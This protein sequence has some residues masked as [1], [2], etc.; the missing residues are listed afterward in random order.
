V[1]IFFIVQLLRGCRLR[2]HATHVYR[3]AR[4]MSTAFI[5]AL[6]LENAKWE[7]AYP[8]S[9]AHMQGARKNARNRYRAF[10]EDSGKLK[11]GMI[12]YINR[13][14]GATVFGNPNWQFAIGPCYSSSQER[15]AEE[16]TV[17]HIRRRARPRTQAV[18]E[19]ADKVVKWVRPTPAHSAY[20]MESETAPA[21]TEMWSVLSILTPLAQAFRQVTRSYNGGDGS[22]ASKRDEEQL[23]LIKALLAL[24]STCKTALCA[25]GDGRLVTRPLRRQGIHLHIRRWDRRMLHVEA[26]GVAVMSACTGI[27]Q[28]VDSLCKKFQTEEAGGMQV[29][30]LMSAW[31][32]EVGHIDYSNGNAC[33]CYDKDEL[34]KHHV[35][36][37]M[38]K[39]TNR[40]G[41]SRKTL[42]GKTDEP[43]SFWKWMMTPMARAIRQKIRDMR[44]RLCA[45]IEQNCAL[46]M[47]P[48]NRPSMYLHGNALGRSDINK[49]GQYIVDGFLFVIEG[50]AAEFGN[51]VR[52]LLADW[53]INVD[54]ARIERDYEEARLS[55]RIAHARRDDRNLSVFLKTSSSEW[56]VDKDANEGPLRIASEMSVNGTL[57][58]SL[59]T[60]EKTESEELAT[61]FLSLCD[62]KAGMYYD[63]HPDAHKSRWNGAYAEPEPHGNPNRDGWD[64]RLGKFDR[65]LSARNS[66]MDEA[67]ES[68]YELQAIRAG[69]RFYSAHALEFEEWIK[70][71]CQLIDRLREERCAPWARNYEWRRALIEAMA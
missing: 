24:R 10:F 13:T 46:L 70:E 18:Y 54:E 44:E 68:F 27:L 5:E 20:P 58:A 41:V 11:P 60:P 1:C 52:K 6:A 55:Q 69:T 43:S 66:S 9:G 16:C 39:S 37:V 4:A 59:D 22:G 36:D 33:A 15:D 71:E 50:Y 35:A 49:R 2:V 8:R 62:A 40:S 45:C 32:R 34:F 38:G 3:S 21:H 63:A 67:F 51:E 7:A 26:F 47:E 31:M 48:R 61:E 29:D 30:A 64:H 14:P 56:F 23:D 25:K 53:K 19:E 28:K 57:C 12:E 65:L 17:A 42:R